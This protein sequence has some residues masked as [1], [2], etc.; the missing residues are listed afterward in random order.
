M[1]SNTHSHS[2]PSE[3]MKSE[4]NR[5]T[6]AYATLIVF[7][8]LIIGHLVNQDWFPVPYP[9]VPGHEILGKVV[10]RG[11]AVT[12]FKVGDLVGVGFIRDSCGKCKQ[13]TLGNDQLCGQVGDN[14]LMPI[15][16]FGGF[17]THVQVPSKWVFPIPSTIPQELAPPLLCAGITVYA[18]LKRYYKPGLKIGIIGIG[19]LGHMAIKFA[20]ALGYQT[21]GISTS[22]D[23]EAEV[24]SYGA[25]GFINSKDSK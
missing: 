23:K 9:L 14:H 19:G 24:K 5:H 22:A 8:Y 6:L 15:P 3:M 11:N 12:A 16:K 13:C 4:F 7:I 25:H 18:P 20:A 17:A 1:Q 2:L 21:Y 10:A